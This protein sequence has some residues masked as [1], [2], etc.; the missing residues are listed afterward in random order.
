MRPEASKI[1]VC[2]WKP[3]Y[4]LSRDGDFVVFVMATDLSGGIQLE[5]YSFN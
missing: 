1:A 4:V 3:G 5:E 2:K